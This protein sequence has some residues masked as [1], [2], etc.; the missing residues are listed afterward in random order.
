MVILLGGAAPQ[1]TFLE[2][3][4][5]RVHA[6]MRTLSHTITCTRVCADTSGAQGAGMHTHGRPSQDRLVSSRHLGSGD[7]KASG[8][9]GE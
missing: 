7:R 9:A 3:T 6:R 1:P 5:T 4:R 2:H 8:G